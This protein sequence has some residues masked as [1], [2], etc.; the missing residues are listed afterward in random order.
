MINFTFDIVSNSY[1]YF[2]IKEMDLTMPYTL[3]Q[4]I[5]NEEKTTKSVGLQGANSYWLTVTSGVPQG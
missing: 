4:I 3:L 2:Y 1:T 5:S